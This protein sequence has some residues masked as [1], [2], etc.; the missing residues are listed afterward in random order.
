MVTTVKV[1]S[2]STHINFDYF[3]TM[4]N[5]VVSRHI[6]LESFTTALHDYKGQTTH[7]FMYCSADAIIG[8]LIAGFRVSILKP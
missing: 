1:I 2:D 3:A 4:G 7:F 8:R 6:R 5:S